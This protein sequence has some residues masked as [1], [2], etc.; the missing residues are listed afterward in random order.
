MD[1]DE[2]LRVVREVTTAFS[3]L[4]I[5]FAI[6]GSM[7]SSLHGIPR[8]TQDADITVE[9][10]P[11]REMDV[12]KSLGPDYYLSLDA[13]RQ[14]NRE[15]SSF[16]VI[17]TSTGFKVDVF[18]RKDHPFAQEVM[19]RRINR[20]LADH[21]NET[22][23]VVSPEDIILLKLEWYRIGQEISDRQWGDVLGV[24]KVQEGRLD[25][26][27]M[28]RW[29]AELGIQDLLNRARREARG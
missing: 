16:N 23:A 21:P 7:A 8:F 4:G 11:T 6:G 9:P 2:N 29:A 20:P 28:D 26:A 5:P 14:A 1:N 17:H 22:V 15:R 18:V 19:A 12:A 3:T 13:M 25:D 10:F 24:L 27:Y